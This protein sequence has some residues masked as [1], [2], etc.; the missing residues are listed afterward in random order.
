MGSPADDLLTQVKSTVEKKVGGKA[1]VGGKKKGG[2]ACFALVD[3]MLRSLGAK[4]AADFDDVTPTSDY[5]WGEPVELK[6]VKPG[7]ILQFRNHT[8]EVRTE[9]LGKLKW[10]VRSETS[11]KRPHHTAVVVE[12]Q[13]DG[14]RRRGRAERKA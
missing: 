9:T 10:E 14:Q 3:Q 7:H 13:E 4:T 5:I 12:V 8:I 1:V 2:I 11:Y 6:S